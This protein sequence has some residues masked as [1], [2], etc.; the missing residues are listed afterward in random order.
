[1]M[2]IFAPCC[3]HCLLLDRRQRASADEAQDVLRYATFFFAFMPLLL[4]RFNNVAAYAFRLIRRR[5][6]YADASCRDV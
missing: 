4:P 1:M 2:L 3:R 5:Y 6:I